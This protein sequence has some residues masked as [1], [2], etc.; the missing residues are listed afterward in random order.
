MIE[1]LKAFI[2]TVSKAASLILPILLC[3]VAVEAFLFIGKARI[4]LDSLYLE[5]ST[6]AGKPKQ[7]L[8]A[9]FQN[10]VDTSQNLEDASQ[11][12]EDTAETVADNPLLK[13]LGIRKRSK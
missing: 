6:F 9:M 10:L 8:E 11:A 12:A 4:I 13:I 7:M 3:C 5:F 1:W 2:E